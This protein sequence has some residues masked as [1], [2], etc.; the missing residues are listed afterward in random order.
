[1]F[2]IPLI[3]LFRAVE[4]SGDLLKTRVCDQKSDA[5]FE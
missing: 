1:M 5:F 4:K 2:K 3:C